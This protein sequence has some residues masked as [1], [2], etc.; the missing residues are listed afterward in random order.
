MSTDAIGEYLELW[1]TMET[2]TLNDQPDKIVWRWTPDGSYSARSAYRMLHTSAVL[3]LGHSLIWQTWAPLRVKIF[4]WL[5]FRRRHWTGDRSAR[6][7]LDAREEC[8]LCDQAHETIN[9]ILCCCLFMREMWFHVCTALG[10]Q[11]PP[12]QHSVLT[13]WRRLRRQWQG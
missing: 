10:R 4:L 7:G 11:L 3:F 5:A 6:H 13:C 12:V 8:Y 9:H 2:V 1:E